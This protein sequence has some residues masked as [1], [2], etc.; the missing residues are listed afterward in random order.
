ML[1]I[2][3]KDLTKIYRRKV[4]QR[5]TALNR[6]NLSINHGEIFGFLGPNGAGK[7]TTIKLI[8]DIIKPSSGT[9]SIFGI[10]SMNP[11]SRERIGY[12]PE[13]PCFYD[14][15]TAKE[16]LLYTAKNHNLVCKNGSIS[17][18]IDDVLDRL[19]LLKVKDTRLR[20]YSKGMVQRAG[21][22]QAVISDPDLLILDEPASGLDPIGRKLV[23]DIMLE[24]KQAGKTIFFSSHILHDVETICDRVG[25]V[26]KG[27]LKYTGKISD[28]LS[29]SYDEYEVICK[30]IE[31]SVL[32]E[33]GKEGLTY[34][35]EGDTF[36]I[37]TGA[38][39]IWEII[40]FIRA[41]GGS[42]LSLQPKRKNLED[43]FFD[44]LQVQK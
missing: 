25:I 7:S 30:D 2:D 17:K 10:P 22:A 31:E 40:D 21:I 18:K 9:V 34:Q 37:V 42:L 4:T 44:F 1:P 16:L 20:K 13:N 6:L 24:Q 28:V 12:L 15:L 38:K 41:S 19:G 39:E 32:A 43:I 14:Y 36:K 5:V 23:S 26:I 27:E 11:R 29:Q 33:K 8:L 35:K 3:I